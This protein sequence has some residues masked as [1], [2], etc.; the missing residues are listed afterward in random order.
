MRRLGRPV[1]AERPGRER[2]RGGSANAAA[3]AAAQPM[4]NA[5]RRGEPGVMG[6]HCQS[7][8]SN[9]GW[10]LPAESWMRSSM[11][12][13]S[14]GLLELDVG[15]APVVALVRALAGEEGDQLVLAVLQVAEVDALDAAAVQRLDL[16][17]GVEVVGD[18]LVVELHLHRVELEHL[19]DVHRDEERDLGVG[20]EQ[21]LLLEHEQVAVELDDVALDVLDAAVERSGDRRARRR[22]RRQRRAHHRRHA[23]RG[24]RAGDAGGGD[25]GGRCRRRGDG[26]GG[27]GGRRRG[28]R[29]RR[30]G[31]RGARGSDRCIGAPGERQGR[32]QDDGGDQFAALFEHGCLSRW[33]RGTPG[34][35]W[36]RSRTG[37][38]CAGR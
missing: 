1:S 5:R 38:R 35:R 14:A 30:R 13:A 26:R 2:R 25:R 12:F 7:L 3:A 4:R 17:R 27:R 21:Q 34:S 24:R 10:S 8:T 28:R 9:S 29:G 15:A 19:A 31:A 20:R 32:G 16:E 33:P 23:R 37:C 18:D 11:Y 6:N 36:R 22:A